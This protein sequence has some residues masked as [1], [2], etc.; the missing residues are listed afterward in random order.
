MVLLAVHF[1]FSSSPV[2]QR[3]WLRSAGFM[4]SLP[5]GQI[6][7]AIAR[8]RQADEE[9]LKEEG[10]EVP[11][12]QQPEAAFPRKLVWKRSCRLVTPF[13]R[14]QDFW[15]VPGR[16]Y[17]FK[18]CTGKIPCFRRQPFVLDCRVKPYFLFP[19]PSPFF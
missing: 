6:A 11:F 19:C 1:H 2:K 3:G 5:G 9:C 7:Q 12:L 17:F 8:P 14:K 10:G 18:R 13:N 4:F 16:T 15:P